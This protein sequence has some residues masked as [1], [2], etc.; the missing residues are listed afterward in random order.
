M[1]AKAKPKKTAA[2]PSA[3]K[4]PFRVK[5]ESIEACN[6]PHGCNCQFAG[7]PNEGKCEAIVGYQVKAGR[8]GN[9]SLNGLR[10]VVA[11]KYPKAI[12]EGHGHVIL[13]VDDNASQEQV[14][15]FT[16]ILS[17]KIGGMP[18]EAL[19]GTIERFEGPI[20]KP[21]EMRLNGVRSELRVPGAVEL[22]LTPLRDSV[23]GKDK[24]VHIVYPKGGFFWNDGNIAT[25]ETMRVEHGNF[26][27]EW[28]NRYAAAA[29]VNWTNQV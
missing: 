20:R 23:S 7:Y 3:A 29:E 12:H 24:E 5:A 6:C 9:V 28:P 8:F 21:I 22:R 1:P 14:D 4:T 10:A 18:W 11:F 25:T 26:R 27:L 15:A 17:G 13:F 16:T 2:R 19:A